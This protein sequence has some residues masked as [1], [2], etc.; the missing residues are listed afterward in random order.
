M[1]SVTCSWSMLGCSGEG[2]SSPNQVQ[3]FASVMAVKVRTAVISA[4]LPLAAAD[5]LNGGCGLACVSRVTSVVA[6]A[7]RAAR[8]VM[9]RV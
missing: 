9:S 1:M 4:L 6:V 8:K 5:V 2:S 3:P 7:R